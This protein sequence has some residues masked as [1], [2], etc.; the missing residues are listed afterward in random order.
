MMKREKLKELGKKPAS[1][2][3]C[4]PQVCNKVNWV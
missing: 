4:P 2:A 3:L 1:K